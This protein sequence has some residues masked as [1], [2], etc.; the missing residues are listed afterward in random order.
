MRTLRPNLRAGY[1]VIGLLVLTVIAYARVVTF[2][3]IYDDAYWL[4]PL[5]LGTGAARW[6]NPFRFAAW[7][8]GGLPWAYHALILGLHLVNG[9]LVYTLARRWLSEYAAVI[10]LLLFWLHPI[11]V[12]AVAYVS[13]G[14][15]VLLTT[16]VLIAVL[17][18]V[19]SSLVLNGIGAFS[20][21]LAVTMKP[22][23]LPLLVAVPLVVWVTKRSLAG[24]DTRCFVAGVPK[25]HLAR[26]VTN[27]AWSWLRVLSSGAIRSH[28]RRLPHGQASTPQRAMLILALFAV[29]AAVVFTSRQTVAGLI[30]SVS[31][32]SRFDALTVLALSVCRYLALLVWPVGFSIEHPATGSVFALLAL[33]VGAAVAYR[34][35]W[36]APGW[37]CAWLAVLLLPR[38]LVPHDT[39]PLTEHHLMLP[40]LSVWMT[41]GSALDRY[42]FHGA[43]HG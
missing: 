39:P 41:A 31:L 13:G 6:V 12:E 4:W 10:V 8:G 18:L 1:A 19:S 43:L 16:Y 3:L 17:G 29:A 33:I 7:I 9:G 42:S 11:Q 36:A 20:L 38:A 34:S 32:S 21:W 24:L 35:R 28:T 2:G 22:S 27:R 15:E 37:A 14:I 40:F 26:G 25:Q 30:G 5:R 23:A